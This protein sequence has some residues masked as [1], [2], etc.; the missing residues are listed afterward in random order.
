MTFTYRGVE[1]GLF[2]HPY[3]TTILNERAV[4]VPIARSFIAAQDSVD[5]LEVGAVLGHYGPTPWR[6]ADRYEAGP[7]VENV[8]LFD[9]DGEVPWLVAVSTVEHVGNWPGEPSDPGRAVAAVEHLLGLSD[10]VLITVPFDQNG[11]LD[12]AILG[13]GFGATRSTTMLW[14]PDGWGEVDGAVWGSRRAPNI[15]PSAV[16]VA[17]W[18]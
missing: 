6:V 12:E 1:M 14:S 15:W 5:G 4:E 3:N 11:P 7:G 2:D 16:W 9:L 17:E 8:D 13:H 18:E 10:R